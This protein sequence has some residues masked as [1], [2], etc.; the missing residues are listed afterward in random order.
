MLGIL[1]AD[2]IH[3]PLDTSGRSTRLARI[4]ESCEPDFVLAA[5]PVKGLLMQLTTEPGYHDSIRIGWMGTDPP[6]EIKTGFSSVDL[7]RYSGNQLYCE[8]KGDDAAHIL[9]TSGS[10][11]V[12]KGVVISHSNVIHFVEWVNKYFGTTSSDRASGHPPLHF[13]LSTF[14]IFGTFAAGAELHLVPPELNLLPNNLSGFIRDAELT[15]W[16]SVPSALTNMAKWDVVR[17]GD[18][19]LLKHVLWCGEVFPTPALIYWMRR[20]PQVQFT[21]LYGPTEA[22][23]SP[24]LWR[25]IRPASRDR[26]YA[27]LM[28]PFE[29]RVS[30]QFCCASGLRSF[31]Q[32][33]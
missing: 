7:N 16:F 26:S 18:F 23:M 29:T 32:R 21:N 8:S 20:L 33:T 13:D 17:P 24:R 15:R 10:T 30:H 5:G 6:E 3:V 28:F 27:A 4:V 19:P 1:K 9:F 2:C 25:L 12:P 14:D 11:G 22:T 31:C